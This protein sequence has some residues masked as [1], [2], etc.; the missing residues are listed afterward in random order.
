MS[1]QTKVEPQTI[2]VESVDPKAPV[3]AAQRTI[4]NRP[5]ALILLDFLLR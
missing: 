3:L 1:Y 4:Y 5:K 2:D